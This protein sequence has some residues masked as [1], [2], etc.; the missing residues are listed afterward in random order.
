MIYSRCP[1]HL[2]VVYLCL[3]QR[4]GDCCENLNELSFPGLS[5]PGINFPGLSFPGLNFPGV[6]S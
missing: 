5:F 2:F 1:S 6:R 4:P 3:S